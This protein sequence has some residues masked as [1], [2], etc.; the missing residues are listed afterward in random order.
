VTLSNSLTFAKTGV[1]IEKKQVRDLSK[2]DQQVHHPTE[3]NKTW[4]SEG[5]E[6]KAG[7]FRRLREDNGGPTRGWKGHHELC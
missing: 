7:V 4:Y 6:K 3:E 1:G 2:W 5:T